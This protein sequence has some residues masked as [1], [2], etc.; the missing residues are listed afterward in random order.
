MKS[1]K[2]VFDIKEGQEDYKV[3][4][5]PTDWLME[6]ITPRR[7]LRYV[8]RSLKRNVRITVIVEEGKGV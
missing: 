5:K 8:P 7:N 6:Y 3:W 1:I 2:K 4:T